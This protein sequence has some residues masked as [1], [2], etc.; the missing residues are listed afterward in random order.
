[1]AITVD[2]L[3][4]I[5]YLGT[6]LHAGAGGGGRKISWAHSCEVP[7]PWNWLDEG[8]LLMTNGYAIAA[9][10]DAQVA[11]VTEL[12]NAGISGLAIGEQQ[13]APPIT[14]EMTACADEL[15]LPVLF[16][17]YEVPFIAVARAVADANQREEQARLL[18]TVRLYD[19]VRESAIEGG[20][21]HGLLD[22]LGRDLNARL[23]VVDRELGKGILAGHESPDDELR[24]VF[25]AALAGRDWPLPALIR[26]EAAERHVMVVPDPLRR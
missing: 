7:N 17:A 24:Q 15:C 14:P 11:F 3:V 23:Y 8:D 16:T 12:A 2:E 22:R 18:Q 19:R 4:A 10:H 1:M 6:R 9:D 5:P 21:S 20:D 13:H 26:M 25:L